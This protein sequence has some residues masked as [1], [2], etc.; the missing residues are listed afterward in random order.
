MWSQ[1]EGKSLDTQKRESHDAEASK[2]TLLLTHSHRHRGT[3]SK[4]SEAV[5]PI[6]RQSTGWSEVVGP[7]SV[8]VKMFPRHDIE[9]VRGSRTRSEVI[10]PESVDVNETGPRS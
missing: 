6:L 3:T 5:G 7:V 4:R 9:A 10:R 8:V 1:G 2:K